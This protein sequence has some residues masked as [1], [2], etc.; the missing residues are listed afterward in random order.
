MFTDLI[1][2]DQLTRV[3]RLVEADQKDLAIQ[4]LMVMIEARQ[5][6]VTERELEM[7]AGMNT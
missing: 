1:V 5:E 7:Q 3:K 2:I 6:R 4:T